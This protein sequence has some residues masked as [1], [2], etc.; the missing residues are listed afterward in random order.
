MKWGVI[1]VLVLSEYDYALSVCCL[2]ANKDYIIL[3]TYIKL[4]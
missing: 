2:M 1:L 3:L 4:T